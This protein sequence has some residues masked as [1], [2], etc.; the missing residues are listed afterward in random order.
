M[1][2]S[3]V[4]PVYNGEVYLR[5]SVDSVLNQTYKHFEL[6]VVN[7]GSTDRTKDILNSLNDDRIKIIHLENNGGAA[8]AL[9]MGIKEAKGEWIAIQDADDISLPNKLEE[10]IRYI[11][12]H[13]DVT[14]VG[15]LIECISGHAEVSRRNLQI[16][17]TRNHLSSKEHINAYRFYLN[18]FCHGSVLFSK[19]IFDQ[20]GGYDLQYKICYDYDLWLRMLERTSIHKIPIV[21]YQYRVHSD[22]ISRNNQVT[23]NED[24]LVAS[25]HIKKRLQDKY[26]REPSFI[27]FGIEEACEDFKQVSLINRIDVSGYFHKDFDDDDMLQLYKERYIDGIIFLE[28]ISLISV[29]Y[30]LQ[31]KGL[32][33]NKNLYKIWAGYYK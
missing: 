27:V 24:W 4:M 9:N 6:I 8:N 1:L 30:K 22:S 5:E 11:R 14:A 29:F 12:K 10:Q 28:D 18:P 17:A 26:K 3:V 33:L 13:K 21:L 31:E 32:E 25:K 15:S 16:E 23:L 7:D 20:I 19:S 2:V